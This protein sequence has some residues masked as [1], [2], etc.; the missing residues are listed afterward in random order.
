MIWM[1]I[2]VSANVFDLQIKKIEV[3]TMQK[4]NHMHADFFSLSINVLYYFI[5]NLF[6]NT[7]TY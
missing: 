6:K 5:V 3:E 7:I 1:Q 4:T 2:N